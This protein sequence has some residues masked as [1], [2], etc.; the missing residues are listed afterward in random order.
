M[1]PKNARHTSSSGS[2]NPRYEQCTISDHPAEQGTEE[3]M[4]K[5]K[6]LVRRSLSMNSVQ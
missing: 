2:E 6:V 5:L 3:C 1:A 4:N